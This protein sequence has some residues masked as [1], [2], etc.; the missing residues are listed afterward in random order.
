MDEEKV[1]F[2]EKAKSQRI[3]HKGTKEECEEW[4]DDYVKK[5]PDRVLII[6]K[7]QTKC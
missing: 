1:Y 4:A 7:G 2:I 3:I 5:N 6:R